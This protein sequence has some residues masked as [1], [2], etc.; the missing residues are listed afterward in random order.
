M[1]N[2]DKFNHIINN[3]AKFGDCQPTKLKSLHPLWG[4]RL[5]WYIMIFTICNCKTYANTTQSSTGN[6]NFKESFLQIIYCV[7]N[8]DFQIISSLKLSY[9]A[10]ESSHKSLIPCPFWLLIFL[11]F[12]SILIHV[13]C[14][15]MSTHNP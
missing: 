5:A 10:H 9:K 7:N 15:D 12:I 1:S 2:Y 13:K 3:S 11:L 4:H 8:C 6:T 14:H